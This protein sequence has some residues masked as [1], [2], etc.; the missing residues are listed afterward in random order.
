MAVE[1]VGVPRSTFPLGARHCGLGLLMSHDPAGVVQ[2]TGG[3][4]PDNPCPSTFSVLSIGHI[5][6]E[7]ILIAWSPSSIR[8]ATFVVGSSTS[9]LTAP[10]G[11]F[12]EHT[13]GVS[14]SAITYPMQ[15]RLTTTKHR[16]CPFPELSSRKCSCDSLDSPA[17]KCRYCKAPTGSSSDSKTNRRMRKSELMTMLEAN[18]VWPAGL[19][20][21]AS[22]RIGHRESL[23]TD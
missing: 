21:S 2:L 22:T 1:G 15:R 23:S 5:R 13:W 8:T 18:V 10:P 11:S 7:A 16:K 12:D 4:K 9:H 14:V 3:W 19:V 20:V 6:A 17:A